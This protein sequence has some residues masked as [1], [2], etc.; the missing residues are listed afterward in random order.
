V[1][2]RWQ[3]MLFEP[4]YEYTGFPF[5]ALL[6]AIGIVGLVLGFAIL[7]WIT[8]ARRMAPITGVPT[9]TRTEGLPTSTGRIA[10][11]RNGPLPSRQGGPSMFG[12]PTGYNADLRALWREVRIGADMRPIKAVEWAD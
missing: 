12:Q 11:K 8:R 1:A 5:G 7:R 4:M 3:V 2:Y 9:A 6:I 10:A